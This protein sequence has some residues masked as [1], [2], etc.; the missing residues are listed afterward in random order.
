MMLIIQSIEVE[1]GDEYIII[2]RIDSRTVYCLMLSIKLYIVSSLGY[3]RPQIW[4][5]MSELHFRPHSPHL[6]AGVV[7]RI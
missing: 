1:Y 3:W 2:E 7:S 6:L 5:A 4:A